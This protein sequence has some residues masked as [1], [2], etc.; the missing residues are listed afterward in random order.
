MEVNHDG[1]ILAT[2]N[3]KFVNAINDLEQSQTFFW[4][5]HNHEFLKSVKQHTEIVTGIQFL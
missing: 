5:L 1:S 2:A 3:G 4:N